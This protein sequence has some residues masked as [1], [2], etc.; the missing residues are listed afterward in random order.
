VSARVGLA[1]AGQYTD[2]ET[3]FQYLRARY[4]D[5]ATGQ[6][7][8]RDPLEAVTRE[9]YGYV[10]GNPLNGT[11]P[12]GLFGFSSITNFVAKHAKVIGQALDV[13]ATIL[14]AAAL[15]AD[16]TGVGAPVGLIL[17]ASSAG[18]SIA[19]EG[20]HCAYGTR[21]ECVTSA[22]VAALSVV[23]VGLASPLGEEAGVAAKLSKPVLRGVQLGAD[24]IGLGVGV[25][26]NPIHPFNMP[27]TEAFCPLRSTTPRVL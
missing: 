20:V 13:G 3:G 23:T 1:D 22:A 12:L 24:A 19:S 14:S 17:G 6:F 2:A 9:P 27:G 25:L 11:D 26:T 7:L 4:Y 16:A 5:P 10:G 15:A 18:L 8:N 21:L